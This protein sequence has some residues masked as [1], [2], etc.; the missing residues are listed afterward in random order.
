MH[1]PEVTREGL[2]KELRDLSEVLVRTAAECHGRITGGE[3][4][5]AVQTTLDFI[6]VLLRR[7]GCIMWE[8]RKAQTKKQED[9]DALAGKMDAR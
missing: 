3:N 8:L 4:D 2:A 6:D 1:R 5:G 9:K 7:G